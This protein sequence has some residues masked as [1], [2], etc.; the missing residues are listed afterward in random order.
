MKNIKKFKAEM[1]KKI[2]AEVEDKLIYDV[3]LSAE[4]EIQEKVGECEC[5]DLPF[6]CEMALGDTMDRMADFISEVAFY[7]LGLG[8]LKD[9]VFSFTYAELHNNVSALLAD[10]EQNG[11]YDSGTYGDKM[12]K[13]LKRVNEILSVSANPN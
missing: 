7:Q 1:A 3:L 9:K 4:N 5:Q 11:F 13:M 6:W 10:F 2:R 12:Y 8:G